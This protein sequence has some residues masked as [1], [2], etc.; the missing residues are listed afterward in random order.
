MSENEE[1]D[2]RLSVL[3]GMLNG[4]ADTRPYT[5]RGGVVDD[6]LLSADVASLLADHRAALRRAFRLGVKWSNDPDVPTNM[7]IDAMLAADEGS[8]K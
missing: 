2:L 6:D 1:R 3:A 8:E 5:K 7:E 4:H